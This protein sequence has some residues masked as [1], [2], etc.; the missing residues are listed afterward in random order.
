[1]VNEPPLHVL[2]VDD[3]PAILEV[4]GTVLEA[5]G[6]SLRLAA[7]VE[8]AVRAIET[9]P[10]DAVVTDVVFDGRPRGEEVLAAANHHLPNAV[11]ILITGFPRVDAAVQ[12]IKLGASDYLTKPVEPT[13]VFETIRRAVNERKLGGEHVPFNDLVEILSGLVAKSIETVDVYTAGH[14]NRTRRYCK[15]VAEDFGLDRT[16][17]EQLELAAIAHDYGKIFLDD[18]GFLTKKGPLTPNERREMQKHPLVGA[19]QLGS[20][21]CMREVVQFIAEHHERWDGLGYPHRLKA[22]EIS[23]PGRILC[24]IE[25]FDSL[26]TIRSYKKAW[27]IQKTLDFFESQAGRAFDPEI[28]DTFLPLLEVNGR[29]WVET[30]KSDLAAAGVLIPSDRPEGA[31]APEG[32]MPLT[33]T[34]VP[35]AGPVAGPVGGD[36]AATAVLESG[37]LEEAS[38][39]ARS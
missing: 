16:T 37:G 29:S 5:Q 12:A 10:F 4:L 19:K 2:L 14:G 15:L 35:V 27:S 28:L 17:V 26:T 30:T 22:S 23:R 32:P 34:T 18:L 36:G 7:T 1:M 39:P 20:N 25:V 31:G 8:D 11:C 3:E 33:R 6:L 21:P 9:E 24:V 38:R 13:A